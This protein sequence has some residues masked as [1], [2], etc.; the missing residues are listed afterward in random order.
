[1]EVFEVEKQALSGL[2]VVGFVTAGVGPLVLKTLATHGAT[3]MLVESAKRPDMTR[4]SSPFKD[5]NPGINRSYRFALRNSDKYSLCLNMKHSRA[6]EVSRRLV[7]WADVIVNNYRPGVLESWGLSYEEAREIKD[8][9][10]MI[11]LSYEGRTGPHRMAAG[12]GGQ[13]AGYAGFVSLAGWPDRAPV[14]VGAYPDIISPRYGIVAIL[15]AL[16][17]RGRTGKGQYI[18]LS[19]YEAAVQFLSPAILDYTVN[20]RIQTQNGNKCPYAVPHGVYRCKGDDEWCAI[21]VFT[22]IEF[23]AFCKVIG[24]PSWTREAKFSTLN[25]R[26]EHEDELNRLVEEWTVNHTAEE[27]MMMMQQA[28]LEAGVVR[29]GR[30]IIKNCPQL[31]HRHYWW[32]LEHPEIGEADYGGNSFILSKTPYQLQRPAPCL[33]EHTHYIC[34]ELLGMSDEE[35]I[36][37]LQDEVLT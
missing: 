16:N 15:A 29:T 17:Y 35:F 4:T 6:K 9:V 36:G 13:L 12:Y 14:T 18:D 26:K 19:E 8:D 37:L 22:D 23:E 7:D 24:S 5:N 20:N 32:T 11:G 10:I 31:E 33:G 1:M 27:I 3:V 30:D 28:G 25:G 34:T 21:A 2:K